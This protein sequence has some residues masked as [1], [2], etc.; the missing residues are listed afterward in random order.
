[1]TTEMYSMYLYDDA[2]LS[3]QVPRR[4]NFVSNSSMLVFSYCPFLQL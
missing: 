4:A 3:V 1:M 2:S